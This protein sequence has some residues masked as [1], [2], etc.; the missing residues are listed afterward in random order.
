MEL[1]KEAKAYFKSKGDAEGLEKLIG[2]W[3]ALINL[4]ERVSDLHDENADLRKRLEREDS[5][6]LHEALQWRMKDGQYEGPF[7]P[8]CW[9]K[10]RA[11]VAMSLDAYADCESRYFCP[12]CKMNFHVGQA[13]VS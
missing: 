6:H 11:D 7:C 5:M 2:I 1:T 4:K 9:G 13:P 8:A 12:A 10:D 3:E